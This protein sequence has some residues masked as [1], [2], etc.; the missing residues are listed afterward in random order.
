MYLECA[1]DR[2]AEANPEFRRFAHSA[3]CDEK[4]KNIPKPKCQIMRWLLAIATVVMA[5]KCTAM[6]DHARMAA[7]EA[8]IKS[9]QETVRTQQAQL[10]ALFLRT[11]GGA[12]VEDSGGVAKTDGTFRVTSARSWEPATRRQSSLLQSSKADNKRLSVSVAIPCIPRHI[13]SL[14]KVC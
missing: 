4:N 8:D 10:D 12:P 14:Q 2:E 5:E 7:L 3:V 1:K 9:L 11:A 6:Y 13:G